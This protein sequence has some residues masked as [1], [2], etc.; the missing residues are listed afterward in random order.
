M[1]YI[2]YIRR[3]FACLVQ[4]YTLPGCLEIM[5]DLL[6]QIK[7]H[8]LS[9]EKKQETLQRGMNLERKRKYKGVVQEDLFV[10]NN[11]GV[12]LR[13]VMDALLLGL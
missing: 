12:C 6:V 8:I 2:Q 9:Q 13:C 4:H 1:I 11:Y 7:W 3:H 5:A 10:T